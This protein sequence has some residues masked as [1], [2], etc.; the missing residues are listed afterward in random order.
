MAPLKLGGQEGGGGSKGAIKKEP[1]SLCPLAPRPQREAGS[2]SV[3]PPLTCCV[4][5]P[6]PGPG[7]S[8]RTDGGCPQGL[9]I[10]VK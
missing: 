4:P 5:G 10:S 1:R 6:D 2:A 8:E 9:T 7:H 3:P